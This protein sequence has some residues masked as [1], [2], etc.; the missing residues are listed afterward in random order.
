MKTYQNIFISI[1]SAI[2]AIT[3]LELAGID[4]TKAN[5]FSF[6]KFSFAILI[7]LSMC[8][9][10]FDTMIKNIILHFREKAFNENFKSKAK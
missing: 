5:V 2:L 8:V 10:A 6:E 9:Y 3:L 1:L 7:L 4:A